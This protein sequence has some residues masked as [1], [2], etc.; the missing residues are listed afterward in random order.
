[1]D[2]DYCRDLVGDFGLYAPAQDCPPE[3][4]EDNQ[5][6]AIYSVESRTHR[7]PIYGDECRRHR[8]F[9]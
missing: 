9:A 6:D 4:G 8:D 1:L 3:F 7:T 2:P 5:I